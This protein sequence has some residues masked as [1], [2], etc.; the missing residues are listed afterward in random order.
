MTSSGS[1][2]HVTVP[3]YTLFNMS[4]KGIQVHALAAHR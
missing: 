4:T 1:P 3:T 2:L